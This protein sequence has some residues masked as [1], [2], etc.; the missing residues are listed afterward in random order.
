MVEVFGAELAVRFDRASVV[1][2]PSLL[3][4]L[5]ANA[6]AVNVVDNVTSQ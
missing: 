1:D 3:A 2:W 6:S 4:G 5:R